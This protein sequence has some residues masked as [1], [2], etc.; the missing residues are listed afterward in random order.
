M[1][2]EIDAADVP[3]EEPKAVPK[4]LHVVKRADQHLKPE[5]RPKKPLVV[6]KRADQ[7]ASRKR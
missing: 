3:N 1:M 6:V 5:P 7:V 4:V 2:I